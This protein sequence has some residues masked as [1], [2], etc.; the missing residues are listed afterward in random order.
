MG[1]MERFV[2]SLS[3]WL[4]NH[5][6][7]VVVVYRS[8]SGKVETTV[9]PSL[10]MKN[11]EEPS[12]H[13]YGKRVPYIF[14][15][16]FLL[17][18]NTI[19]IFKIIS[20]NRKFNFQVLHAVDL[21]YDGFAAVIASWITKVP[22]I[23]HCHGIRYYALQ[24]KLSGRK[25]A[26]ICALFGHLLEIFAVRHS[27]IIVTINE[28]SRSF[29]VSLGFSPEKIR[30]LPIGVDPSVFKEADSVRNSTRKKL[31][32]GRS[33][34]LICFIGRLDVEKNVG[35]LIRAYID[36]LTRGRIVNSHLLIVGSGS[37]RNELEENIEG[38][39]KHK[40]IFTGARIDVSRFLSASDIF[41]LP[42]FF[43]GCPTA[44]IEAMAAGKAIVASDLPSIREIIRDE[45]N[46]LLVKPG[47]K[48]ALSR[49]LERLYEDGVLRAML[50]KNAEEQAESYD[51]E[52][53][54]PQI[55]EIYKEATQS[56]S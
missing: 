32:I 18:V 14:Y 38:S 3:R 8:L 6:Y 1:G 37:L 30:V 12:A 55:L 23:T 28:E 41:V 50:A 42:S 52:T 35:G 16:I 4:Q 40:V 51:V 33:K 43:E 11:L 47:N 2:R 22:V 20:L 56:R 27:K 49:T 45:Y 9:N 46:G 26:K 34:V 44:L 21:A 17:F 24:K 7:G 5:S 25:L 13:A 48:E 53:L 29:F 19:K 39:F 31:G 54:Y 10:T 15:M 36:L